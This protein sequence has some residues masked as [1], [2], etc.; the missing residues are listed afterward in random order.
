MKGQFPQLEKNIT[1][2][3]QN[4]SSYD[5]MIHTVVPPAVPPMHGSGHDASFINDTQEIQYAS[6]N[7]HTPKIWETKLSDGIL[8]LW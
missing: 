4:G 2:N 7:F 6:V 8:K 3:K 1:I 5:K